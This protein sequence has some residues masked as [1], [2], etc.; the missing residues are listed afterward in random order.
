M[1]FRYY[2]FLYSI[3]SWILQR[4]FPS[5]RASFHLIVWGA[6]ETI[7]QRTQ[8]HNIYFN[9][10]ISSNYCFL[11][12]WSVALWVMLHLCVITSRSQRGRTVDRTQL[13]F[14]ETAIKSAS[15]R[16]AQTVLCLTKASALRYTNQTHRCSF[17]INKWAAKAS[18]WAG[19]RLR[20]TVQG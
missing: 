20:A 3:S 17:V 4:D 15:R 8:Q 16:P 1:S 10:P 2:L 7:R 11:P 18:R 12:L 9:Q 13:R 19:E 6:R 5:S 14:T